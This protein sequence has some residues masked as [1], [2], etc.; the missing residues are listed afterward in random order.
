MSSVRFCWWCG[1]LFDK[2]SSPT[3]INLHGFDHLVH[4]SCSES[5]GVLQQQ[6]QLTAQL[7]QKEEKEDEYSAY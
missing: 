5:E 4:K 3:L 1:R 6:H 7:R 2:F